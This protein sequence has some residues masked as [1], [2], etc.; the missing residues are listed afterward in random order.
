MHKHTTRAASRDKH[1]DTEM[2][3]LTD[4]E[5]DRHSQRDKHKETEMDKGTNTKRQR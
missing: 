5:T 1:R 2:N 3:R 4:T